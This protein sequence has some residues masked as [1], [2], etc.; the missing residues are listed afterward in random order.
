MKNL[1]IADL[2]PGMMT[3]VDI[4]TPTG[5][6]LLPAGS[7]LTSRHIRMLN[8]RGVDDVAIACA[9]RDRQPAPSPGPADIEEIHGRITQRFQH[10]DSSHPFVSELMR[11]CESRI[12]NRE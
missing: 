4:L 3:A 8:A 12:L 11:L 1:K 5:H 2:E 7:K 6:V 10:N 9:S